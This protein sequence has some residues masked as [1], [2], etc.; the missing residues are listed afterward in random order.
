MKAQL[1]LQAS[2]RTVIAMRRL[3]LMREAVY[4]IMHAY[5]SYLVRLAY[6]QRHAVWLIKREHELAEK[7]A[8]KAQP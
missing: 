6:E 1:L 5:R 8:T 2:G 4:I 3:R 7:V